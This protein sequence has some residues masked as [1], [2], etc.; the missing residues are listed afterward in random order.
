MEDPKKTEIMTI[1]RKI[2]KPFH[3][4]LIMNNTIIYQVTGH[5]HLR[6]E[7][8][9]DGSWEKHIHLNRSLFSV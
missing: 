5:K 6:F 8:S 9:N 4:P 7:I 3:P 2:N 1:T